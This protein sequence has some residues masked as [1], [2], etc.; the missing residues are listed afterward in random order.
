[1]LCHGE[2]LEQLQSSTKFSIYFKFII[3]T[4][5][6]CYITTRLRNNLPEVVTSRPIENSIVALKPEI[7]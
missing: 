5:K 1:M 6:V 7:I 4:N 3:E 2:L